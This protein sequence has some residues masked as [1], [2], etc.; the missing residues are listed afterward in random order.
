MTTVRKLGFIVLLIVSFAFWLYST[1]G[2][3]NG[4]FFEDKL[5]LQLMVLGGAISIV[6]ASILA[7]WD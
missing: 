4:G 5:D 6:V 1:P 3:S 2:A 7:L